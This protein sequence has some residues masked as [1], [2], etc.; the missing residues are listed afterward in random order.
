MPTFDIGAQ[1][2]APGQGLLM[3]LDPAYQAKQIANDQARLQL[4]QAQL[5]QDGFPTDKDG[6]PDW[7]TASLKSAQAGDYASAEKFQ[8]IGQQQ[9]ALSIAQRNAGTVGQYGGAAPASGGGAG[10]PGAGGGLMSALAGSQPAAGGGAIAPSAGGD[11]YGRAPGGGYGGTG[12]VGAGGL[13]GA[14][15]VPAS[16]QRPAAAPGGQGGASTGGNFD[17]IDVFAHSIGSLESG[18]KYDALGPKQANGT[19]AVGRYQVMTSN[20]PSWTKEVLGQAMSAEDFRNNQHPFA[21]GSNAV[22]GTRS[23]L[24][25]PGGVQPVTQGAQPGDPQSGGGIQPISFGGGAPAAGGAVPAPPQAVAP[26]RLPHRPR[27]I[28]RHRPAGRRGPGG[29]RGEAEG[30]RGRGG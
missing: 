16:G 1:S 23:P 10:A 26:R 27:R 6:N 13:G 21:P 17:Q 28:R 20:I 7:G 15:P 22:T 18:N 19:Q 3:G 11:D 5:F 8:T 24:M 25:A 14:A 12:Q 30:F 2:I 29:P 4:R 9:S